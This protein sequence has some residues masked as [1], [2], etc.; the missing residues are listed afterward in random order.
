MLYLELGVK[1]YEN[2]DFLWQ[3]FQKVI[4]V[5]IA[6]Q[7]FQKANELA[8]RYLIFTDGLGHHN[9][10]YADALYYAFV[11]KR[12]IGDINFLLAKSKDLLDVT[13]LA[14]GEKS[15]Q[16]IEAVKEM[17][18]TNMYTYQNNEAYKYWLKAFELAKEVHESEVNMMASSILL[19]MAAIKLALAQFDD[20]INLC[21]KAKKIE[22]QVSSI[23]SAKYKAI[24]NL[25]KV[26][27]ETKI[28]YEEK[29][30]SFKT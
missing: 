26:I 10:N 19:E 30:V 12:A 25:E 2:I 4:N 16:Y 28:K 17:A 18:Y 7:N 1:F 27:K 20:S 15:T 9:K 5:L 8:E 23:H 21:E 22:E 14:Y 29:H 11:S 3:T 6:M 13:K 24:I